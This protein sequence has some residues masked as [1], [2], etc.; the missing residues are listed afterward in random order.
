MSDLMTRSDC[1]FLLWFTRDA[2]RLVLS[3]R[4]RSG[5]DVSSHLKDD[6][7]EVF[8]ECLSWK[9]L[10]QVTFGRERSH[11]DCAALGLPDPLPHLL[12]VP[13]SVCVAD[14]CLTGISVSAD[15]YIAD[16]IQRL[17]RERGRRVSLSPLFWLSRCV[18]TDKGPVTL[19][20]I[21]GW[22][23]M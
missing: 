22:S 15:L 16:I 18:Q 21:D 19:S 23:G 17:D 20:V 3:F 11:A 12:H 7:A 10:C 13:L 14:T 9:H 5:W 2:E 4:F 1:L 8:I 6:K